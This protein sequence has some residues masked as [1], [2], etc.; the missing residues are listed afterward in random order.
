MGND[1]ACRMDGIDTIRIKMF[2][3]VERELTEV[4]YVLQMKKN[5]ISVGAVES[6]RL[7]VSWRMVF[8]R[9]RR[10]PWL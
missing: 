1:E 9:S 2:N 6:K 7:K 10:D 5:I 3:G 4:R 8:L